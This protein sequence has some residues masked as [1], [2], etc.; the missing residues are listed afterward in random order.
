M[1]PSF[2]IL[3]KADKCIYH[4]NF[5]FSWRDNPLVALGLLIHEVSRTHNGAPLSVGF[6]WTSDQSVA[7]TST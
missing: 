7:E 1:Y 6:P 3:G 2:L 5:F 4:W